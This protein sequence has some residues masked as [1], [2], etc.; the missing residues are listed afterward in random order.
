MYKIR[1]E[2]S[3]MATEVKERD[4]QIE[5]LQEQHDELVK[6]A[7]KLILQEKEINMLQGDLER[8]LDII[9]QVDKHLKTLMKYLKN[10][11]DQSMDP[12]IIEHTQRQ[13]TNIDKVHKDIKKTIYNRDCA[14]VASKHLETLFGAEE[15]VAAKLGNLSCDDIKSA[16]MKSGLVS[17]ATS[18]RGS[19]D[20]ALK[21]LNSGASPKAST[22][23][24]VKEPSASSSRSN[25]SRGK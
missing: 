18:N 6:K 24:N 1:M 3:K 17:E 5:T 23:D 16:L 2:N 10:V 25:K 11:V 19:L 8:F 15:G 22:K 9:S 7:A 21:S 13:I 14:S 12:V 4:H 20:A